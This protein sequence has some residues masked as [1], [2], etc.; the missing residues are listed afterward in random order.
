MRYYGVKLLQIWNLGKFYSDRGCE[1]RSIENI[2]K[3]NMRYYGVKPV[4]IRN[5]VKFDSDCS[6]EL[7]KTENS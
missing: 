7:R 1:H 3:P 2:K 5:L 6:S 4:E